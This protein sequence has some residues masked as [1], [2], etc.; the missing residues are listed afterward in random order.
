MELKLT[1]ENLGFEGHVLVRVATNIERLKILDKV[2]ISM[3]DFASNEKDG[4]EVESAE[5]KFNNMSTMIKLLEISKDFYKEVLLS[6][7]EKDFLSFDDLNED[8][9]CQAIQMDVAMKGLL[10]LGDTKKK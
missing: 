6:K 3:N 2:G 8:M 10:N 7:D 5:S 9:E 1:Y 4:K